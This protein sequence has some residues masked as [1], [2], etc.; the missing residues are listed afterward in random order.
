M[1][2]TT[3]RLGADISNWTALDQRQAD[4]L[5]GL[6]D[7]VCIGL[8]DR[9]KARDFRAMITGDGNDV[10]E[11]QSYSDQLGRDMS[12][13]L[14]GEWN[15][16]DLE[17]GPFF[18]TQ[19]EVRDQ[20]TLNTQLGLKTAIYTNP[21]GFQPIFGDS[22]ELADYGC[23]LIY[24]DYRSPLWNTFEPFNGWGSPAA[25]Q[26]SSM[27]LHLPAGFGALDINCDLLVAP[28]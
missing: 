6:M 27:G 2:P 7:F 17:K 8:Q 19:Q 16:V 13:C 4:W 24:A 15:W 21:T 11:F 23:P 22:T 28:A 26:C 25:W 3:R 10:P 9:I 14:A 18:K 5:H 12:S 20:G 1:S